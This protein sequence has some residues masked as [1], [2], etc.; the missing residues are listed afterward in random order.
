MHL[1]QSVIMAAFNNH[2]E[3]KARLHLVRLFENVSKHYNMTWHVA[4]TFML[5]LLG[6]KASATINGSSMLF[7]LTPTLRTGRNITIDTIIRLVSRMKGELE[8]M[9]IIKSPDYTDTTD[10]NDI[11][12]TDQTSKFISYNEPMVSKGSCGV[13]PMHVVFKFIANMV[14]TTAEG[15]MTVV[16]VPTVIKAFDSGAS[17]LHTYMHRVATDNI[18]LGSDSIFCLATPYTAAVDRLN[19]CTGIAL[20]DRIIQLQ[21]D[22]SVVQ[23]KGLS[24]ND[25]IVRPNDLGNDACVLMDAVQLR[26]QGIRMVGKASPLLIDGRAAGLSCPVCLDK[27]PLFARLVCNHLFCVDCIQKHMTADGCV[28]RTCPMCRAVIKLCATAE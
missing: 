22:R 15:V 3:Y 21:Q 1:L 4:G 13:E 6:G 9:G 16:K 24:S 7:L 17:L 8:V 25:G 19:R 28:E 23:L 10:T 12:T 18:L 20:L 14:V 2:S 5:Y 26:S 27:K 11:M